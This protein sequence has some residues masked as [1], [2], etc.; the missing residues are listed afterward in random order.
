VAR[1]K[2]R[3]GWGSA[4]QA[5]HVARSLEQMP[6]RDERWRKG[7]LAPASEDLATARETDPERSVI[8]AISR[9][10]QLEPIP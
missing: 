5:V 10:K 9:G 6:M 3:L 8:E 2:V 7:D 1:R 4:R